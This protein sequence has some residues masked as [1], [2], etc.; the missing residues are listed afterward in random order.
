MNRL[1]RGVIA[2]AAGTVALD[3]TTYGDMLLRGRAASRVPAEVAGVLAAQVGLRP[4]AAG[5]VGE[6]ADNRR[7]AAGALL[8][9]GAGIGL[10]A[11]YGLLRGARRGAVSPLAGVA[12]GL[13][14]M[15]A[16]DLPIALT[17][18]SD[19]ATW[20]TADWLSD[21]IPH[22]VYGLATVAVYEAMGE[23]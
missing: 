20:S 15:A 17:G 12:V 1:V 6:T 9:Y 3:L 11:L 18:V 8:G 2:G 5:V 16:S 13:G 14:A 4:L 21:V 10:G 22:L 19:P 7:Q 23:G